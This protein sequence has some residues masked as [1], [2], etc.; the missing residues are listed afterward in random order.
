MNKKLI[1][2][3]ILF[4]ILAISTIAYSGFI[5]YRVNQLDTMD[6]ETEVMGFV[7]DSNGDPLSGVEV[8]TKFQSTNTSEDGGFYLD[9]VKVGIVD[10]EFY[11]PGYVPVELSW[12]CYPTSDFED[13]L[14][15]SPNNIT[16]EQD[17]TLFREMKTV[18]EEDYP[19][20]GNIILSYDISS[21]PEIIGKTLTV[22]DENGTILETVLETSGQFTIEVSTN[23]GFQL[24]GANLTFS[25]QL[26]PGAIVDIT[27]GLVWM[28]TGDPDNLFQKVETTISISGGEPFQTYIV[29]IRDPI[30]GLSPTVALVDD[31]GKWEYVIDL[32]QG[33]YEVT[34]TGRDIRDIK[35]VGNNFNENETAVELEIIS[36]EPEKILDGL[37]LGPNYILAL[38]MFVIGCLFFLGIYFTVKGKNWILP[39]AIAFLGFIAR[40]MYIEFINVNMLIASATVILLFLSREVFQERLRLS[41]ENETQS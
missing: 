4:V 9:M 21:Y 41:R 6:E 13:D 37:A 7:R 36:A 22:S 10:F 28:S 23:L 1:V 29:D 8:T 39:V 32:N 15:G 2:V 12:L 33:R 30:D 14:E 35:Y 27:P 18:Y 31:E 26:V 25:W 5:A 38:I 11:L 40:G 17:I 20:N 24:T 19:E 34:I 16:T 3:I